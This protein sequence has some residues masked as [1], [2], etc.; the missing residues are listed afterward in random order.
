MKFAKIQL[1]L[2]PPDWKDKSN[3]P[4][5]RWMLKAAART[6]R[7]EKWPYS[8]DRLAPFEK[9]NDPERY[10]LLHR[11]HDQKKYKIR[12]ITYILL[13]KSLLNMPYLIEKRPLLGGEFER[14]F[15]KIPTQ[16]GFMLPQKTWLLIHK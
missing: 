4:L 13:R 10:L 8:I 1:V 5:R 7:R 2:N 15:S 3:Q 11:H 16:I 9:K 14:R 6:Q 12:N